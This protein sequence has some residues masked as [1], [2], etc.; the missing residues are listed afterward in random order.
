MVVDTPRVRG[1]VQR[2]YGA[3]FSC[4]QTQQRSAMSTADTH[5]QAQK[6]ESGNSVHSATQAE[7]AY[8]QLLRQLKIFYGCTT[9]KLTYRTGPFTVII[10]L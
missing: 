8:T 7:H 10:V 1:A 9:G 3:I 2:Y 5:G 4:Q 6:I